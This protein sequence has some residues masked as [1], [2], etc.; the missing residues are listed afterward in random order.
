MRQWPHHLLSVRD[1]EAAEIDELFRQ[2]A[3][4]E[5]RFDREDKKQPTLTGR[6]VFNLFLE[7]STRTRASFELAGKRLGADVVNITAA[8]SSV[9]KGESLLDTLKT[10]DAMATDILVLRHPAAGAAVFAQAHVRCSVVNGGDGMH[11]HPTQALLDAYSLRKRLGELN[12]RRVLICGD[13]LHS[14]VARSNTWLLQKLGCKVC[15]VGP[16]TLLPRELE[17]WQVELFDR[18]PAALE[19]A[20]A[21]IVLRIQKERIR[22]A[23]IPDLDEYAAFFGLHQPLAKLKTPVPCILHPGPVNRGIE[24]SSA[25]ADS[26]HSAIL[27]QVRAGV[28]LRMAVISALRAESKS[29]GFNAPVESAQIDAKEP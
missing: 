4:F 3:V 25:I 6:T 27:D 1:L 5:K 13:V 9:Q 19:N 11:E 18:L 8:A 28:A 22:G 17:Y 12:G 10:L 23:L 16:R 29:W 21:V 26:P 20:D 15:M 14:R 2:A 7:P 24:I